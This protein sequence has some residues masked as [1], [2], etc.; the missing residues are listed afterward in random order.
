MSQHDAHFSCFAP[1]T[2]LKHACLQKYLSAWAPKVAMDGRQHPVLALVDAF[3]GEGAD[4][5]GRPGSPLIM[6]DAAAALRRVVA[7]HRSAPPRVEVL[8]IERRRKAYGKLCEAVALY[9]EEQR[10]HVRTERGTLAQF[11]PELLDLYADAP[12]LVFLDPFGVKGLK[13]QDV[14]QS[15][16]G[17]QHEV[18]IQFNP[19]AAERLFGVV[20]TTKPKI[21]QQLNA[22]KEQGSLFDSA[23]DLRAQLDEELET[24]Q[25]QF[26]H[27]KQ[28]VQ[29]HLEEALG[30]AEWSQLL[31][32]MPPAERDSATVIDVYAHALA[33]AGAPYVTRLPIYNVRGT[34]QYVL[35][36]ASKHPIG[37][38]A[39]KEAYATALRQA[40]LPDEVKE[41]M[42]AD[43]RVSPQAI[44]EGLLSFCGQTARWAK[45]APG[46]IQE[47]L[48]R[49]TDVFPFQLKDIKAGMR[50][51]GWR[52]GG[53]TV[54]FK[55]PEDPQSFAPVESL[56]YIS[57][58]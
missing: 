45:N 18:L 39:I 15:L 50:K 24:R 23:A 32:T 8:L 17:P 20:G 49:E 3:A 6:I 40:E 29:G 30:H 55:I 16:A 36:H 1:H 57:A 47:H 54:E 28:K 14:R 9:P 51:A 34:L 27:M 33:E 21:A 10:R 58:A 46:S 35:L 11:V 2:R 43:L 19:V 41:A 22:Q 26:A 44:R 48:L 4:G 38:Q 12:M 42:A 52:V 5:E 53:R 37:R 13:L 31:S 7:Q 56:R 25:R